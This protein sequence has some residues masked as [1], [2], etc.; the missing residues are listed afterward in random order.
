M[1]RSN[2]NA[3]QRFDSIE[4][5]EGLKRDISTYLAKVGFV[6]RVMADI[7]EIPGKTRKILLW[8]CFC[9]LNIFLLIVL[10][11]NPS[12]LIQFLQGDLGEFF[13]LFLGISLLGGL[14]GL[15]AVSDLSRLKDH[16]PKQ[17]SSDEQKLTADR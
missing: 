10:G 14:I 6:D 5:K 4:P 11:T 13:F 8:S 17:D 3:A 9:L 7:L 12:V 16:L 1:T 2:L 15:V